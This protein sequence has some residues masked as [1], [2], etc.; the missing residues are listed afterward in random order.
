MFYKCEN[1]DIENYASDTTLY[2]CAS[3]IDT[4]ISELQLTSS[5]LFTWSN[6]NNMKAKPE[7][8]YF[9]LSSKTQKKQPIVEIKLK[10]C[11]EIKLMLIYLICNKVVKK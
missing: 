2:D 3:D 10:N 4:L 1:C 6:N 8:S 7:K 5:R 11:I 9:H